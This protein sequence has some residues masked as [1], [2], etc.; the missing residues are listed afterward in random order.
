[1]RGMFGGE[2]KAF[3]QEN[4]DAISESGADGGVYIVYK[5]GKPFYIGRS[6]SNVR[7]RLY[8]HSR[9]IGSKAIAA[10][11]HSRLT[12]E[13]TTEIISVEQVEAEL[14]RSFGT[15][16]RLIDSEDLSKRNRGNLANVLDPAAKYPNPAVTAFSK[17]SDPR[18]RGKQ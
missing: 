11:N 14:V 8:K 9:N 16:A 2:I 10:Q 7:H 1:M 12:F 17:R 4:V 13:F 15:Y 3:T 18:F 5:D 6:I